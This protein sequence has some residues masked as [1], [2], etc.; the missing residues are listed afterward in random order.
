RGT[1][2][3]SYDLLDPAEQALFRR[4]AVF[5]GG[6]TLDAAEAVCGEPLLDGLASLVDKSLLERR[7][8][9]D[10]EPRFAMLETIREYALELLDQSGDAERMR[11]AHARFFV[12]L[13]E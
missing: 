4:V 12:A 5:E 7:D 10:G 3:W 1:I 9:L 2:D 13:A 6:C 8:G 11:D